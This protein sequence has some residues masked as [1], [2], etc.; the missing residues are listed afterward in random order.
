MRNTIDKAIAGIVC[1]QF[2]G[3]SNPYARFTRV[4]RTYSSL[5]RFPGTRIVAQLLLR[6]NGEIRRP[7][8][9]ELSCLLGVLAVWKRRFEYGRTSSPT[10][11]GTDLDVWGEYPVLVSGSI[12]WPPQGGLRGCWAGSAARHGGSMPSSH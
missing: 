4:G 2:G 5:P 12:L 11:P 8:G 1:G 3:T 6:A 7:A 10:E 9:L